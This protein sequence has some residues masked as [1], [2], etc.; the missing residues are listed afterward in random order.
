MGAS[1][2]SYNNITIVMKYKNIFL[3]VFAIIWTIG[4]I[5]EQLYWI[6]IGN[7]RITTFLL[8]LCML[9]LPFILYKT[10]KDDL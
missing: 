7:Y 1:D 3:I 8:S 2:I 5:I 10:L 6:S 9:S 4:L